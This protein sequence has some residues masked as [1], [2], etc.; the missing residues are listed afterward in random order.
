MS[1]GKIQRESS[2]FQY[3]R[4]KELLTFFVFHEEFSAS[5]DVAK[6]LGISE[7]TLRTD[8]Y[9]LNE[10]L[11]HYDAEVIQ[12]R[13]KGY[14]LQ[15]K[16]IKAIKDLLKEE[17]DSVLDSADERINYLI[18]TLLYEN[19]YISQSQ[20]SDV[21]YVSTNTILNYLKAIRAVL[22]EYELKLSN[23]I[24]CGY[25]VIG[26]ETNKRLCLM[27][28]FESSLY[29]NG[30]D[31]WG[32]QV[33]IPQKV[34]LEKIQDIVLKF[35][36]KNG[37]SFSD[38]NLRNLVLHIGIASSRICSG[39]EIQSYELLESEKMTRILEPLRKSLEQA[40]GISFSDPEKKYI[41]SCYILNASNFPTT[42]V[43]DMKYVNGLVRKVLREIY[44]CYQID[45]MDDAIL[46]RDLAR[47][48]QSVLWSKYYYI[49]KKNPILE[50]IRQNYLLYYEI[51]ETAVY[52]AFQNESFSM[53]ANDI[54]Y[55]CLHIGAAVR[56]YFDARNIKYRRAIIINLSG[57]SMGNLIESQLNSL[58]DGKLK[59]V[60]KLSLC[61]VENMDLSSVDFLI[62]TVHLKKIKIPVVV[63]DIPLKKEDIENIFQEIVIGNAQRFQWLEEIFH[64]DC[65]IRL[66]CNKKEEVIHKI[67]ER[68]LEKGYVKKDFEEKVMERENRIPTIM[69]HV[70]AVPHPMQICALKNAVAVGILKK[71]VPWG[72]GK[73]AQIVVMLALSTD[74]EKNI[75]ELYD[76]LLTMMDNTNLQKLLLESRTMDE[77]LEILRENLH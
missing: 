7:R 39:F 9:N 62:S 5:A 37:F 51:T 36:K 63:I 60:G 30:F 3:G 19:E 68:L 11:K 71:P 42:E 77:F 34:K 33:I 67:S 32:K 75:E 53:N 48:F 40:T 17:E 14:I 65:F 70:I 55:M 18:I 38:Y 72:V 25:R 29:G 58:F 74:Y 13:R 52:Q 26:S 66:D 35:N 50:T 54:G 73:N 22:K 1:I 21:V 23:K 6:Y 4:L 24:N 20:L 76:I 47:H 59:I 10:I 49:D 8:I 2:N 44:D 15:S 31:F 56:R 45:V 64:K 69:D 57:Y 12:R 28:L 43:I 27:N 61:D 46:Q 16:S 41:Y